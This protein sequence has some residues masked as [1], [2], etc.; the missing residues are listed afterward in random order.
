MNGPGDTMYAELLAEPRRCDGSCG[1]DDQ[2]HAVTGRDV[3]ALGLGA[4]VAG[5]DSLTEWVSELG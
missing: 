3:Q 5:L 4:T 2:A 1:V